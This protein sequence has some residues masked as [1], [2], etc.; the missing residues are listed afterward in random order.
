MEIISLTLVAIV[1]FCAFCFGFLV[2][3]KIPSYEPSKPKQN[4]FSEFDSQLLL[5]VFN[6]YRG[7][8]IREELYE[9]LPTVDQIIDSLMKG[10][11]TPSIDQYQINCMMINFPQFGKSDLAFY[12]TKK[13]A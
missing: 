7:R 4:A 12:V 1:G 5:E 11:H 9:E 2:C 3:F 6:S 10:T 13:S 8:I